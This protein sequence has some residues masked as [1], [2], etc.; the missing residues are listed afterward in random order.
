MSDAE[1]RALERDVHARLP[2]ARDRL[3]LALE[4]AGVLDAYDRALRELL[5]GAQGLMGSRMRVPPP[6][7]RGNS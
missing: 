7:R 3:R 4:R 1:L 6:S 2:G 5:E